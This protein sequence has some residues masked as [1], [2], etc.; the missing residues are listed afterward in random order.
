[1]SIY[2]SIFTGIVIDTK[3]GYVDVSGSIVSLLAA[4]EP[5]VTKG[6]L[7]EST[8]SILTIGGGTNSVIGSGVTIQVKQAA[9]AQSGY[10]SSTD[11]NTFNN[12]QAALTIGNLT[13][14]TTTISGGTGAVIGSGVTVELPQSIATTATPTFAGLSVIKEQDGTTSTIVKNVSTGTSAAARMYVYNSETD[15]FQFIKFGK[16]HATLADLNRIYSTSGDMEIYPVGGSL[17][18]N[19]TVGVVGT[20]N[21]SKITS[22]GYTLTEIKA[23]TGTDGKLAFCT[24]TGLQ[25][26]YLTLGSAYTADDNT[27]LTTGDGGNTRWLFVGLV[28]T[29]TFAGLSLTAGSINIPTGQ[30]YKINNVALAYGDVGAA[31]SSHAHGNITNA[32]YLGVAESIPLIT[33][34][35]GVI[36]AGAF[37]TGATNFAAGNHAHASVY[38]PL[39]DQRLRTTDSPT[40]S[41]VTANQIINSGITWTSRTS[42]ADNEWYSIC[43]GNGLFVAVSN[44]GTNNRVMTSPDGNTWTSRTSAADNAWLSICYGNGLFVAV[45]ISG[46]NNRVMTSGKQTIQQND[47]YGIF[48]G[49]AKLNSQTPSTLLSLDANKNIISL[50][51]Q[52][53]I[54]DPSGQTTD[55]DVEARTAIN[56]IIDALIAL[57]LMN[58]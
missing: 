31:A 44:T 43:Y 40:F 20:L 38:Q 32:G 16:S 5:T 18:L 12:K 47:S 41:S 36:Q 14:S 11:W 55:L 52:S 54:A 7:T 46:T 17:S 23:L 34:V 37:G 3:L 6:N 2:K 53:L 1:M 15:N 49:I 33:G 28:A 58:S 21:T 9:T 25:Y 26:R 48:N 42:A 57:N 4:K 30:S 22:T 29:P 27:V 8:S 13:S 39:E 35:G 56:S 10:L 50:A 51:K 45:S 24:E 19:C